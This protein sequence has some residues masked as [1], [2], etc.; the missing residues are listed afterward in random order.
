MTS[1]AT[2][3]DGS[4]PITY[5]MGGTQYSVPSASGVKSNFSATMKVNR[6]Q[7]GVYAVTTRWHAGYGLNLVKH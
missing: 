2:N 4:S 7:S 5:A 1:P 6:S 3:T